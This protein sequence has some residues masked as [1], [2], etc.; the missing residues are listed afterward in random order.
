MA[1][2]FGQDIA[3]RDSGDKEKES[4][5]TEALIL[6]D[7]SILPAI[8]PN[9]GDQSSL[10]YATAYNHGCI[11]GLLIRPEYQMSQS[12]QSIVLAGST[13]LVVCTT[14]PNNPVEIANGS[15]L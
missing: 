7:P 1:I 14:H 13:G 8:S 11:R 6:S 12:L 9:G 4:R 3:L 2:E 10:P 5:S 15:I